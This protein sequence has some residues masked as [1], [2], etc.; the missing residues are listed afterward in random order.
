MA[1]EEKPKMT[2]KEAEAAYAAL[3]NLPMQLANAVDVLAGDTNRVFLGAV[4]LLAQP[5][6]LKML[7]TALRAGI[8]GLSQQGMQIA[9]KPIVPGV[10]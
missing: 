10:E 1:L 8:G 4:T 7:D 5:E 2:Q 9:S 6:G 3:P